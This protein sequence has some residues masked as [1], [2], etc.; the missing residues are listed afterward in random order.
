MNS[1]TRIFAAFLL[2]TMA[3]FWAQAQAAADG[4]EEFQSPPVDGLILKIWVHNSDGNHNSDGAIA[5]GW[6]TANSQTETVAL[7][8]DEFLCNAQLFDA[9]GQ[10]VPLK[11]HLRGLGRLFPAL[12]YPAPEQSWA[13]V[14]DTVRTTTGHRGVKWPDTLSAGPH[15]GDSR[16][17]SSIDAMF[18]V[19]APGVYRARFQFQV[20][21]VIHPG[22][23]LV[24]YKLERFDPVEFAVRKGWKG[25]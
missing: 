12:R 20:Y 14:Q 7:P 8:K 17:L 4:V 11:P 3:A 18:Q 21:K 13:A 5:Y 16:P 19:S 25:R 22:R 1:V 15:H 23:G 2:L 6:F 24:A 9:V 10:P